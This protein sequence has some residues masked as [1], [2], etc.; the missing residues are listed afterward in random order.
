M[1]SYKNKVIVNYKVK[2]ETSIFFT[3]PYDQG[4]S[5]YQ[6][7]KKLQ[8]QQAQTGFMKIDVPE[9]EGTYYPFLY[10]KRICCWCKFFSYSHYCLYFL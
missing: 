9:G 6:N 10:S 8:I 4:W 5:A 2:N 3:I 7:G 1:Q